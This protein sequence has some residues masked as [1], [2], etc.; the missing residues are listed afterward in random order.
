MGDIPNG[1]WARF[2]FWLA[3]FPNLVDFLNYPQYEICF[4]TLVR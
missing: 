2:Q 4:R 1:L 3:K